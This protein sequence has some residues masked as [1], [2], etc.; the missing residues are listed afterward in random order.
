VTICVGSLYSDNDEARPTAAI[1]TYECFGFRKFWAGSEAAYKADGWVFASGDVG[2]QTGTEFSFLFLGVS[3]EFRFRRFG[4]VGL[5]KCRQPHSSLTPHS[6]VTPS[7][8]PP[9]SLLTPS[10]FMPTCNIS[11][12]PAARKPRMRYVAADTHRNPL[13]FPAE[14]VVA[15]VA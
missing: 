2:N 7:S 13:S 10:C 3:R 4:R 9:H 1:C 6:F 5:S 15:A 8:L 14:Q 11:S 12:P